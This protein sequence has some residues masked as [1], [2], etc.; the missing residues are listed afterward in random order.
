M[1][2]ADPGGAGPTSVR[3]PR[4]SAVRR[5][6]QRSVREERREFLVEGPHGVALALAVPGLVRQ[7]F[8]T[9]EALQ[10]HPQWPGDVPP[11]VVADNVLAAMAETRQPQGVVAVCGFVDLPLE[12]AV[13][14]AP[15]P[16]LAALLWQ[17][18]DP[19]NAGTILRT[20]DAAGAA[21]VIT[22]TESV[23]VYNGKCVRAT[24]GSLFAVPIVRGA[25]VL[26]AIEALRGHG[27]TVLAADGAGTTQLY[28]L[29]PTSQSP[30]VLSGSV[31]WV[32]G[33]EARGLDASVAEAVDLTVA[34]PHAG[35]AES[36]NLAAAAAVC[37]MTTAAAQAGR[38]AQP[39]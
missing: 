39:R 38:I 28:D 35:R 23:D 26:S 2:P 34:I 22:S 29:L 30:G 15:S 7:W 9:A 1:T 36:L 24:A 32:F 5:L 33:N 20:A 4:V 27:F 16:G 6:Q 17:V 18:R 31:C 12:T 10:A 37:L 11:V 3:S 13:A 19:G 8:A 21:A 14:A 25:N